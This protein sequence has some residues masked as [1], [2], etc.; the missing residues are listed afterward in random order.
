MF[1]D[2]YFLYNTVMAK[3][4]HWLNTKNI[5]KVVVIIAAILLIVS[6]FA[7]LFFV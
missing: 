5:W 4:P 1:Y 7:P 2:L 6:S 3:K